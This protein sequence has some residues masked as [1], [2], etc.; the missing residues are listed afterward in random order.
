MKDII[1]M[2]LGFV[3]TGIIGNLLLQ[4]WQQ[5]SWLNQQRFLGGE[6][7]FI[8][9][10][11][12]WDEIVSSSGIRLARMRRL[13]AVIRKDDLELIRKRL[14][15]YDEA[16]L[17]WNEKFGSFIVRLLRYTSA[18]DGLTY[19]LE[20][21]VQPNFV[22]AG[23]QLELL[24]NERVAGRSVARKDAEG[25]TRKLDQLS[26]T[27]TVFN[28]DILVV[29]QKQKSRTYDGVK[30]VL[31]EETISEFRNWE[32]FKALFHR[33]V[34]PYYVVR[35]SFDLSFPRRRRT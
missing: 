3:L 6:R 14:S 24:V 29:V 8:A 33:G 32:L 11:A 34:Q 7:D 10:K 13:S 21:V 1:T 27:L 19:S 35:P 15:E 2:V 18:S 22:A 17:G 5:R 31:T 20:N 25:V 16:V 9:L 12:L 28:R 30:I 4:S 26:H 23:R